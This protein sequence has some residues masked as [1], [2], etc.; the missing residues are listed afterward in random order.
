MNSRGA[1][2]TRNLFQ[3]G[4]HEQGEDQK[5]RKKKVFSSK[6]FTNSGYRL[7]NF[8][9][10]LSEDQKNK[11]RSSSPQEFYEIWCESTKVTKIRAVNNN[12]GVLGLDL[13]SCSPKPVNFFGA[14]SS[15]GGAQFLFGGGTAPEC[16]PMAPGLNFRQPE[17]YEILC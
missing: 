1:R 8:H 13:H 3:S 10:F 7:K 2:G 12:L 6:F 4:S 17:L 15:L 5:K 9:K 16:S 11:K 14:Q